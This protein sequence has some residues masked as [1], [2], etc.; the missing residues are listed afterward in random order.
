MKSKW[1]KDLNIRPETMKLVQESAGDKLKSIGTSN[2]FLNRTQMAQ[3][4]RKR[5]HKWDYMKIKSF[6]TSKEM[7]SK[8]KNGRQPLPAIHLTRGS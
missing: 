3:Q 1:I 5:I 2:T 4:L 7:V 8:L 6:C